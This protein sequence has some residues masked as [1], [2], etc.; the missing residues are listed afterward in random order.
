MSSSPAIRGARSASKAVANLFDPPGKPF[1]WAHHEERDRIRAHLRRRHGY[2]A[3]GYDA[4]LEFH[5]T[6]VQMRLHKYDPTF[7]ERQRRARA[8]APPPAGTDGFLTWEEWER[9]A[10]HFAGA[11]DPVT[12]SIAAKAAE[13][14]SQ[15]PPNQP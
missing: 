10:E 2:P 15:R 4:P 9:L 3:R 8:A 11:N 7:A 5:V 6:R 1:G 14:M 12:A 13:A